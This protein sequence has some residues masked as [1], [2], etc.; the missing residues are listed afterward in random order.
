MHPFKIKDI[1]LKRSVQCPA[2]NVMPDDEKEH[3]SII[4]FNDIEH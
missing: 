1:S 4:F 2:M 3:Q